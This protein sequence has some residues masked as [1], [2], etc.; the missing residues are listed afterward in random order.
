MRHLLHFAVKE[1][2]RIEDYLVV[3]RMFEKM[4][5][6]SVRNIFHDR[7]CADFKNGFLEWEVKWFG[8]FGYLDKNRFTRFRSFSSSER[9]FYQYISVFLQNFGTGCIHYNINYRIK[10]LRI[11]NCELQISHYMLFIKIFSAI[12]SYSTNSTKK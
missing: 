7:M 3:I 11:I 1:M 8:A 10:R 9:E 5:A 12:N 2:T 6:D 4:L